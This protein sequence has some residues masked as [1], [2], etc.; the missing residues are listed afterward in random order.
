MKINKIKVLGLALTVMITACG[1]SGT[2][3]NNI[4][5]QNEEIIKDAIDNNFQAVSP[6]SIEKMVFSDDRIDLI[7][8]SINVDGIVFECNNKSKRDLQ[9]YFMISLDGIYQ[10]MWSDVNESTVISGET[11]EIIC[12]SQEMMSNTEHKKLSIKGIGFVDNT[13]YMSFDV[14]DFDLGGMSNPE[15]LVQGTPVY[16]SE[17]LAVEF[18]GFFAQ[19][20]EIKI[21]NKTGKSLSFSL[22]NLMLNEDVNG[23]GS[24]FIIPARTEG[25]LQHYVTSYVQNFNGDDI[26]SFTGTI[27]VDI[28][29]KGRVSLCNLKY[30]NGKIESVLLTKALNLKDDSEKTLE[31]ITEKVPESKESYSV[32]QKAYEAASHMKKSDLTGGKGKWKYKGLLLTKADCEWI[33]SSLNKEGSVE[34]GAIYRKVGYLLEGFESK[35]NSG[36]DYCSM[37]FGIS[38][39]SRDAM[40][41][42][43]ESMKGF[44]SEKYPIVSVMKKFSGLSSISGDFNFEFGNLGKYTIVINDTTECA[45]ELMISDEMFGYIIAMLTEYNAEI[46]FEGDTCTINYDGFS[47]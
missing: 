25:L 18:I 32:T 3:T 42:Y 23:Y 15:T 2:K 28:P 10:H 22:E 21:N 16:E 46:K 4:E 47:E 29:E 20:I 43:I 39:E 24:T 1:S 19:G 26:Y 14:V 41:P 35:L 11:K 36:Q 6:F 7:C 40:V 31:I 44:Y 45:K 34:A 30:E 12:H 13:E 8:K 33:D 37:V 9:L 38:F 17:D 27:S 5:Q